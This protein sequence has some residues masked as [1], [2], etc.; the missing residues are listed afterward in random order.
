M[1][2]Q[3][4]RKIHNFILQKNDSN[5][6]NKRGIWNNGAVKQTDTKQRWFSLFM[7]I[8]TLSELNGFE[9]NCTYEHKVMYLLCVLLF[10]LLLLYFFKRKKNY[11]RTSINNKNVQSTKMYLILYHYFYVYIFFIHYTILIFTFTPFSIMLTYFTWV[12]KCIALLN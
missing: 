8:R 6:K 9:K 1:G 3:R 12:N 5:L 11:P 10:S 2:E 7:F 4:I